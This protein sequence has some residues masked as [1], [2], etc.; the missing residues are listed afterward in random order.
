VDAVRT[1][2][3]EIGEAFNDFRRSTAL[4]QLLII[5]SLGVL[6]QEDLARFTPET[7]QFVE[8]WSES[9]RD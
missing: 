7:P 8:K 9:S 2:F 3:K 6:T 1:Q 4:R 5:D